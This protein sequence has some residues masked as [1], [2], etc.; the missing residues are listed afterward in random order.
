MSYVKLAPLP[1]KWP[2]H[3]PSIHQILELPLQPSVSCE[4]LT[5]QHSA[6]ITD[7]GWS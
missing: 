3:W 6:Q 1:F 2:P 5:T 4:V 7:T